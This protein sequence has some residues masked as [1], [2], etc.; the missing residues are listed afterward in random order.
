[1]T[2][3]KKDTN[4]EYEPIESL[5]EIVGKDGEKLDPIEQNQDTVEVT[6]EN[7]SN[8]EALEKLIAD[9]GTDQ[10]NILDE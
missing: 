4:E 7:S 3:D 6:E 8:R 9:D 2:D 1:M 10:E 5:N